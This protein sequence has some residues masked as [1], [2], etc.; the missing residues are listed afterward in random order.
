MIRLVYIHA[1][2]YL[3]SNELIEKTIRIQGRHWLF[4]CSLNMGR[5]TEDFPVAIVMIQKT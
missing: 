5:A 4:G 2:E 3:M 1:A